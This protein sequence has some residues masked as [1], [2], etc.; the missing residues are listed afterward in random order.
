MRIL[1]ICSAR[2]FGGGERHFVNLTNGL[3]ERGHDVYVAAPPD[4][5][6]LSELKRG[7]ERN[8]FHLS[9]VNAVNVTKAFALRRFA[10]EHQIEII[11]AHMARDYPLAALAVGRAGTAQLVI[12]RHVLFPM[13]GLHRLTRRRV[14][15][16]I[17][18]SESVA[19]SLRAQGIFDD[20]QI[21]VVRNGIDLSRFRATPRKDPTARL[22]VG[23]L[24]ELAP[25]KGQID[26]VRAAE[27][28]AA[29]NHNVEFIIAGSD[30]SPDGHYGRRLKQLI[31]ASGFS[32]RIQLIESKID[33]AELLSSLDLLVSASRS[34][35]FGLAIVEAMAC[36]VPVVA[37]ATD[38]AREIIEDDRTG[39]VVKV[40]DVNELSGAISHLLRDGDERR[41]IS[42]NARAMVRERFS[43]DRMI[44]ETEAV[45]RDVLDN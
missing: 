10:R 3:I 23:I 27:L 40:N 37:T 12:T 24:G 7:A 2:H 18:V 19:A 42:Q 21:T 36:G 25:N 13:S 29:E 41:R 33:V 34:E 4:S 26:F 9:H 28:V 44:T 17:A 39:R 16:V 1:Q 15:R 8:I 11:H 14:S 45:Y 22:R 32:E 31:Q 35:A 43:L 6:I 5:P 38:G 30:Q 20:G